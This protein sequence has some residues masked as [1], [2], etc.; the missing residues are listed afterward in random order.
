MNE[1]AQMINSSLPH[2]PVESANSAEST[3]PAMVAETQEESYLQEEYDE[4]FVYSKAIVN[5]KQLISDW[6]TEVTKTESRRR[7]RKL[8]IDVASLRTRGRLLDDETII[9]LRVIDTNIRREQPAYLN[10]LKG[11]NRL[12]IFQDLENPTTDTQRIERDFSTG[13]M[14]N[15]WEIPHYKVLDG[16]Q[17][18]G[19]DAVEVV[20]NPEAPLHYVLEHVGHDRLFF[21][22]GCQD[23]QK[24]GLVIRAYS[25]NKFQ[26]KNAV[27]KFGFDKTQVDL[28]IQ[29]IADNKQPTN[30]NKFTIYKVMFKWNS[31]VYVAWFNVDVTSEWVKMPSKLFLGNKTILPDGN[32]IDAEE[33]QYPYFIYTYIEGEEQSIVEH[34]GRADLDMYDQDAQTAILSGYVNGLTRASNI[35]GS[36]KNGDPSRTAPPKQLETKLTNGAIYDVPLEF[37]HTPYPDSTTLSSLNL[38]NARKSQDVGQLDFAVQNRKDSR[39]TATENM[40]ASQQAA[41]LSSVQV[42]LYSAFLSDVYTFVWRCV[43]N[44]A[45]QNVIVFVAN[46]VEM[47]DTLTQQVT[48]RWVNDLELI[49]KNYI[50]KAA[51]DADVIQRAETLNRMKQDLAVI[52]TINPELTTEFTKAMLELGYPLQYPKWLPLLDKAETD[53]KQLIAKMLQV[54]NGIVTPEIMQNLPPEAQ[55]NMN[56][57]QQ[58]AQAILGGQNGPAMMK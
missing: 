15:G 36:I 41:A 18:H 40:L 43:Q 32:V 12:A 28:I 17:T 46:P 56:Q 7:L 52:S 21:E 22:L 44:R 8:D 39:K 4:L 50:V 26:L 53:S 5:I 24:S 20:F 37:T 30:S 42:G 29:S 2:Y 45:S 58:E 25:F 3:E 35:Y 14:Y 9:P 16:S 10:F 55:Q 54:L 19:W 47:I 23:I 49:N 1:I 27:R 13:M 57:I 51:G 38:I 31:C 11:S 34:M 6:T 33:H 48:I